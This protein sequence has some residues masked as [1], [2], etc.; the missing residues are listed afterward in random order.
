M[1]AFVVVNLWNGVVNCWDVVGFCTLSF[2]DGVPGSDVTG[3]ICYLDSCM[4]L[5]PCLAGM[6]DVS[7]STMVPQDVGSSVDQLDVELSEN[8]QAALESFNEVFG[9][10]RATMRLVGDIVSRDPELW[11]CER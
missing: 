4:R 7:Y 9:R 2:A 1:C 6:I 3:L 8:D 10:Q 11:D 5:V